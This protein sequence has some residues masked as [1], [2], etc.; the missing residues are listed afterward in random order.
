MQASPSKNLGTMKGVS[1]EGPI[2][3]VMVGK[4]ETVGRLD[5][6]RI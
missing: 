4:K 1:K 2:Y 3:S 5:N 6:Y